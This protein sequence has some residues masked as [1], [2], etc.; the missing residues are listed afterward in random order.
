MSSNLEQGGGVLTVADKINEIGFGSYQ[1]QCFIMC[2]G[3][4][5]A[6]ASSLQTA[7]GLSKA[8]AQEF[9]ITTD[10]G[11]STHLLFVYGGFAV[12][13]LCSGTLGDEYGRR[14]PMLIGFIG[15]ILCNFLVFLAPGYWLLC[16]AFCCLGW[17][18]GVGLP[19]AFITVAEI[20]PSSLRGLTNAAM[21]AAFVCGELWGATGFRILLPQLTGDHWRTLPLWIMLPPMALLCFGMVT[22]VSGFDTPPFLAV[23]GRTASLAAVIN[24]MAEMNGKPECCITA[25]NSIVAEKQEVMSMGQAVKTLTTW[26]LS[27][28]VAALN[29]LFFTKDIAFYGMGVFWPLAWQE[30]PS[31]DGMVPATENLLT[32]SLGLPGVAMALILCNS[33]PR[34]IAY[35]G[36]ALLCS[37]GVICVNGILNHNAVVGVTGVILFKVFYPTVQMTTFLLPSEVFSTQA[38]VWSMSLIGCFGRLATLLA[39]ILVNSDKSR[40]LLI[41]SSLLFATVT[42]VWLLPETKGANLV[43]SSMEA[44]MEK[45]KLALKKDEMTY[46]SAGSLLTSKAA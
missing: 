13:T 30:T 21:S 20:T 43:N 16:T 5:V 12:G 29:L 26:P 27:L 18:A 19:G 23:R 4:V 45:E 46:G 41:T 25:D 35:A 2:A 6:E 38:R 3:L 8:I 1:I 42:A 33:L 17:F 32:A 11:K 15:I 34:R 10:L 31:I 39:P 9:N 28:Y 7:S 40:F 37:I 36:A 22:R 24:L 44:E 14:L